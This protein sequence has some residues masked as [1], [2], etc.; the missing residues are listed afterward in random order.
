MTSNERSQKHTSGRF[1]STNPARL[2]I[3]LGTHITMHRQEGLAI[4]GAVSR[5]LQLSTG[6]ADQG[7]RFSLE[8]RESVHEAPAKAQL[9]HYRSFA[10]SILACFKIGKSESASFQR[11]KKSWYAVLA[12]S[13]SCVSVVVA[14][15]QGNISLGELRIEVVATA[16]DELRKA[17]GLSREAAVGSAIVETLD[18]STCFLLPLEAMTGRFAS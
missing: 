8:F 10:Y 18:M 11:A 13:V 7:S 1:R 14:D 16:K 9:E 17:L 2:R 12:F 4:L 6:P 15:S 3:A 5:A